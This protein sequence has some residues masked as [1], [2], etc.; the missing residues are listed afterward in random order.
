MHGAN[1]GF[2]IVMELAGI[3]A[4][5]AAEAAGGA[6]TDLRAKS[7]LSREHV[8]RPEP[9]ACK[10]AFGG[11]R[12]SCPRC[13]LAPRAGG[14]PW[15]SVI[16]S[17]QER[18]GTDGGAQNDRSPGGLPPAR[19]HLADGGRLRAEVPRRLR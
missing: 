5:P 11:C 14:R 7:R 4:P 16:S 12:V 9:G 3:P 17:S 2:R 1:S 18:A 19:L 15:A 8:G 10:A 13:S 6:G